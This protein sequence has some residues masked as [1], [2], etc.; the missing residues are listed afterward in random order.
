MARFLI[1]LPHEAE[2]VAC[3]TAIRLLLETGSH[4]ITNADWGCRDGDHRGWIIVDVDS[5]E[6]ARAILPPTYRHEAKVVKLNKFTLAEI[7]DILAH[8]QA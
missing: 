2:V 1:E 4:F 5:R 8:H 7:D 6:E 3:A